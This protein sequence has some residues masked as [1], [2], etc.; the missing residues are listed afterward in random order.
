M[1]SIF[2]VTDKIFCGMIDTYDFLSEHISVIVK[3]IFIGC[4][5][6]LFSFVIKL[7]WNYIGAGWTGLPTIT[8][9]QSLFLYFLHTLLTGF[10]KL[11]RIVDE[12]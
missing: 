1:T 9:A 4:A 6:L 11:E 12:Q 7:I 2:T 8:F 10:Y 3:P 5:I